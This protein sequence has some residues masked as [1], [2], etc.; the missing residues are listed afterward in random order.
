MTLLISQLPEPISTSTWA[1]AA[2]DTATAHTERE[3][4]AAGT[5]CPAPVEFHGSHLERDRCTIAEQT[6]PSRSLWAAGRSTIGEERRDQQV[7][8]PRSPGRGRPVPRGRRKRRRRPCCS[9]LGTSPRPA[10]GQSRPGL[11]PT[12]GK[13]C[14]SSPPPPQV[15]PGTAAGG[16]ALGHRRRRSRGRGR[17]APWWR[18]AEPEAAGS[19]AARGRLRRF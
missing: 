8:A 12:G 2:R 9:V 10:R 6:L 13:D 15:E 4:F 16:A 3:P 17:S 1:P 19:S 11:A 18:S 14:P 5:E 7:P